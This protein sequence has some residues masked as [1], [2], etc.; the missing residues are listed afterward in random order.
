MEGPYTADTSL[1][2]VC[3]FKYSEAA[4]KKMSGAPIELDKHL[5]GVINSLRTRGEFRG[6]PLDTILIN[7]KAGAIGAKS[8]LLIGLGSEDQLSLDLMEQVGQTALRHAKEIGATK[9]AFAPLLRDQG[10]STLGVGAIETAVVKGVLLAYDTEL[11][12]QEEGLSK[13]YKLEEWSVEAGPMYFD[14]TVVGVREAVSQAAIENAKRPAASLG[15][16]QH[17]VGTHWRAAAWM[18]ERAFPNRF[19]KPDPGAF[20][21]RQAR[22]LLNEAL[23]VIGSEISDP[24]KFGRIEKRLRGTF[25]YYIRA[26]CDRRRTT[27][28]VRQAMKFFDDKNAAPQPFSEFGVTVPDFDALMNASPA[29]SSPSQPRRKEQGAKPS[30]PPA[31]RRRSMEDVLAELRKRASTPNSAEPAAAPDSAPSNLNNQPT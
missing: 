23:G 29:T 2:V 11:R 22:E 12:L 4:A 9:V 6:E 28:S 16:G 30:S 3:Y 19:A 13:N 31:A 15:S 5:G 21:A 25:E 18:L 10:N 1:Q 8:L 27:R 17:A 7:P 24:F 14:E 26:A 20:G